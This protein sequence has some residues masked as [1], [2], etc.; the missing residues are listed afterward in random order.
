MRPIETRDYERLERISS[1]AASC[2][3]ECGYTVYF[4]QDQCWRRRIELVTDRAVR[5]VSAGGTCETEPAFSPDG[6]ALYFLTDGRV[7]CLELAALETTIV[8]TP[9]EG[10]EAYGFAV[11]ENAL[12]VKVRKE[13]REEPPE[14]CD[15]QMPL[16]AQ[17]LHYRNDAD[18]GFTKKYDRKLLLVQSDGETAELDQG[19]GDWQH[20]TAAGGMRLV[21]A[22][23]PWQ[24]LDC[25]TREIICLDETVIGTAC[26]P[27]VQTDGGSMLAACLDKETYEMQLRVFDL[28]SVGS[29]HPVQHTADLVLCGGAYCDASPEKATR[30]AACPDGSWLVVM[31]SAAVPQLWRVSAGEDGYRAE[32]FSRN[33]GS[34]FECAANGENI[35]AL[36]G[37]ST[38]AMSLFA[39]TPNGEKQFCAADPNTWLH[40]C[41]VYPLH[42]LQ[43]PAL[44]GKA[45][46]HGW[47][48]LP[49]E[50]RNAPVLL[51]I[52]G[53]PEGFF[54]EG[55][56]LELQAAVS[57][58]FAVVM[59]NPRGST[60][61]GSAY[62]HGGQEF[63]EGAA[64]DVLMLLD[65]VLRAHPEL[66]ASRI[67]VL[68]GSY[69]G[70]MSARLAGT[71]RRFQAAVVIKPVTNWL[72]IHFKSS[73]SGQDVFENHR[74]FQDFLVDTL[75]QSPVYHAGDVEIPTLII[76]GEQDQ[77]CPVD[78]AHQF[79]V[80]VRDTH[81]DLPV[82]L[83]VMPDCCH[84]YSRDHLRDYL[85][86]QNETLA[87]M[88][89]YV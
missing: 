46:L 44:D 62:Q 56:Y 71:T 6:S 29:S 79:Y 36:C 70:Y 16:V 60:G 35:W 59:P 15:W 81:P 24:M 43:T 69:G 86:I 82:R 83:M 89:K 61:Y 78:N 31:T 80:A 66:D 28:H 22:K 50:P 39:L 51:W 54:A 72:F 67:G 77:T 40:E 18:H 55:L 47:Y 4:W 3:G 58:G 49:D 27:S 23:G 10:Y 19:S 34:I 74:D 1:L 68:G 87:W 73:Q 14:G 45:L 17:E 9:D 11:M 76:H 64:T 41:T 32:R 21:Y 2:K 65:A 38:H 57:R 12:A 53:G 33:E 20:L 75:Q 52:H 7:G 13:I 37:D 84:G 8:Y 85:T 42:R 25:T 63:G 30:L 48:L 26:A 5:K 88:E